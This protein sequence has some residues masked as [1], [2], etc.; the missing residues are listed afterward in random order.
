[1]IRQRRGATVAIRM[2]GGGGGGG[3]RGGRGRW[4]GGRG[5]DV[6]VIFAPAAAEKLLLGMGLA[7][8]KGGRKEAIAVGCSRP[9]PEGCGIG[10]EWAVLRRQRVWQ[11]CRLLHC[12]LGNSSE[13]GMIVREGSAL[14][15]II[16]TASANAITTSSVHSR[17]SVLLLLLLLRRVVNLPL[18]SLL[19]I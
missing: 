16:S 9:R 12:L 4:G 13:L 6:A 18:L 10:V 3:W 17:R 14:L 2:G 5:A 7:L 8:Q 15:R 11:L 1:M 19:V